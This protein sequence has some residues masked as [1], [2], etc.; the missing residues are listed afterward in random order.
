MKTFNL[1]ATVT[2]SLYTQVEAETLEEAIEK[3]EQRSIEKSAWGD[4]EQKKEVWV[5]GEYDGEPTDIN[6]V[7]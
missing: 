3:S 5:A 1:Y 6:E 7:E 4:K 2:I